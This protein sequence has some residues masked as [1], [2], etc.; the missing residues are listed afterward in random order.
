MII[1]SENRQ[2]KNWILF[3][4][5]CIGLDADSILEMFGEQ[6]LLWC[7]ESGYAKTL[8][9]LGRSLKDFLTNLD[10]LHDHLSIIYEGMHAPSFRCTEQGG[11]LHLHYYSERGLDSIVIGVVKSVGR[12][13]YGTEVDVSVVSKKDDSHDHTIFSIIE[14]GS[15]NTNFSRD[16]NSAPVN[17]SPSSWRPDLQ[18]VPPKTFC[19]AFP[20]HIIFQSYIGYPSSGTFS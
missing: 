20:F 1:E 16:M 7:Q 19:S 15:C 4:F 17:T 8:Q 18:L 11:K 14:I 10:A 13:L 9:L 2:V 12:E 6:F 3:L 5:L